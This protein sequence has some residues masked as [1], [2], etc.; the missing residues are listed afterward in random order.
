M[1]ERRTRVEQ[2][3]R[4]ICD[5]LWSLMEKKAFSEISVSEVCQTA[6]VSRNTFYRRFRGL[7]DVLDYYLERE[8]SDILTQYSTLEHFDKRNPSEE[9]IKRTYNR[10][11]GFWDGRREK[12]QILHDQGLLHLLDKAFLKAVPVIGPKTYEEF[13]NPTDPEY[14]AD[15]FYFWHAV[16]LS[17]IL[18]KWVMRGCQEN[19][20]ELTNITIW[21]HQTVNYRREEG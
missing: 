16:S 13:A 21:L 20:E 14:F 4:L 6:T 15:Y 1:S 11:Y 9:D 3:I 19:T 7:E 12:L 18:E 5:A 2:S 17:Q 10:F 8:A